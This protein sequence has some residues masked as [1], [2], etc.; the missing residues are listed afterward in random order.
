VFGWQ[1]IH[2]TWTDLV[3]RPKETIRAIAGSLQQ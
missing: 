3:E 2:V 1:V